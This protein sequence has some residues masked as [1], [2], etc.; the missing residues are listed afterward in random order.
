MS[1]RLDGRSAIVTGSGRGI[2]REVALQLAREGA[3]VV[4]N[5]LDVDPAEETIGL[6]RAAGGEAISCIGS[7]TDPGFA[8]RIVGTTVEAFGGIDIVINNAGYTWDAI[9]QRTTDEQWAAMLEVHATAPFRILR[10]IQPV[11]AGAAKAELR[12]SGA[13]RC[14]KVVNITSV[15]GLAGNAGQAGYSA[16]K[17]ALGGLTRTIAKEW[18]RYNVTVNAVAFGLISTRLTG[19]VADGGEID[20][21]GQRIHVGVNDELIE[22]ARANIPLGRPGTPA[23]AA[24]AVLLMCLPESDYITGQTLVCGGGW[25][26]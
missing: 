22:S 8:E 12:E 4:V 11:I 14:R 13:A 6:I 15:S 18:G 17:A 24:G 10:A 5:D 7:V 26:G 2:G 1:L 3:R 23:E 9:L 16:A 19:S 20:I 25:E 21:A